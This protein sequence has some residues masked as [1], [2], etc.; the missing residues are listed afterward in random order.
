MSQTE[1]S[2]AK[3]ILLEKYLRGERPQATRTANTITR[4]TLGSSKPLSFGQERL[5]FLAQLVPDSP[6]Y[7]E[8]VTIHLPGSLDVVA[9]RQSFNEVIRR[10]EAWRTSFPLVDGEPTQMLHA[11]TPF[12]LPVLDLRDLPDAERETEALRRVTEE[13]KILFDLAHGPLLRAKL[14]RLSDT[15]HRLFLTLHQLIFDGVSLYQV[16]LPELRTLYEAFSSGKPSPL[17][18]IPIQYTDFAVWQRQ[19]VQGEILEKQLAYWKQ[20]LMNAPATLNIPADHLHPP[21]RT[22]GGSMCT[23]A[24]SK[25]VTDA[26]KTLCKQ[27]RVTL[28][29]ALLAAFNTLLYH[30]TGQDDI[31]IGTATAGRKRGEVQELMGFFLNTVVLRTSLTG[32]PT[33]RELL[34]RA[35]NVISSAFAH[36]DVP[37][38]YVVKNMHPERGPGRNPFFRA[39]LVLEPILPILPSGWTLTQMDVKTGITEIDLTLELDDRPEGLIGRFEYSTDLFEVTTIERMITHWQTL[40]ESIVTNP[41]QRLSDVSILPELEKYRVLQEWNDT[42]TVYPTDIC[43]H[44]LFEMQVEQTPNAI[45]LT[46]KD[47]QLTYQELNQR[48]NQIAHY[49]RR[50]NVGPEV[51]VGI[52]VERSLEM[53]VSILGILKAGGA[54]VPLDPTYPQ[55]RLAFLLQ[56]ADVSVLVTQDR[57]IERLPQH[58]TRILSLDADWKNIAQESSQNLVHTATPENLAYVMYTSGSTGQPKGV[59]ITHRSTV[60]FIHWAISAF[61]HEDLSGVLASTS[62]CFDLSIFE[63]FAPLSSGGTVLLIENV[64][65]L[66]DVPSNQHVTLINTVPSAMAQLLHSGP[67]PAS[68]R[69]VNLAGE[70]LSNTLTQQIYQQNTVHQVFNLYGP[71][72]T[73]TYATFALVER[74]E[75]EPHIGRPIANTQIYIL[76]ASMQPVPIGVIGDL[77]IGGDGLARG[78]LNRP[79]ATTEHFIPNPFSQNPDSRLYKTGD[80]ARYRHDGNIEFV[81]RNDYQVKIRGHRIELEEIEVSLRQHP[82]VQEAVVVVQENTPD[83]KRLIAYIV[84]TQRHSLLIEHIREYL[85]EKLPAYMVPSALT[86]LNALP[87]THSNKIDRRALPIPRWTEKIAE[88]T[89]A[90]PTSVVHYQLKQIWEKLLDTQP[91]GIRDNFFNLGGHSLLAACMVNQFEQVSGKKIAL[92]A[93]FAGPTIEQLANTLLEDKEC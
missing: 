46:F 30:Y 23:F 58:T 32:N 50:L 14:I 38:E 76:D 26:L 73:T 61:T 1:I 43:L 34:V 82:E 13:A 78:Y 70:P 52:C 92:S 35:R 41:E 15:E 56:D 55:D 79:A 81:G 59:A 10:H 68:V 75:Q 83:D 47:M 88:E 28:F 57:L 54:Y 39:M 6:V 72:E 17:A 19:W 89:Y 87:L 42:K 5:W 37:F 91:I 62:I 4:Q 63:M 24:L 48:A 71:T 80:L 44:Q 77:Y 36:E 21:T 7:N 18:E 66:P 29:M 45:A 22:Y 86:L 69:T 49:L 2:A 33:F 20:Q 85:R 8:C 93:L 40:L 11:P 67:L 90:P 74:R 16:F 60:A 53:I 84:P 9:L 51:S 27:E 3:R 25:G 64:L 31:L 12:P 65:H